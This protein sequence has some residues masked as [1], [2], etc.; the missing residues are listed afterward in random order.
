MLNFPLN[1]SY[2]YNLTIDGAWRA[3]RRAMCPNN[4]SVNNNFLL[5]P[6]LFAKVNALLVPQPDRRSQ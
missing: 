6:P 5:F 2:I 1:L 3:V 4:I